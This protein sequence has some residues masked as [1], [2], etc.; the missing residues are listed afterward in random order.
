MM[1]FYL[2]RKESEYEEKFDAIRRVVVK[3]GAIRKG[4]KSELFRWMVD[5]FYHYFNADINALGIEKKDFQKKMD[6]FREEIKN[7]PEKIKFEGDENE[8]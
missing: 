3:S 4:S 2:G 1:S 6:S 7:A 5:K 8:S